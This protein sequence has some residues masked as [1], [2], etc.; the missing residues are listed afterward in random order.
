MHSGAKAATRSVPGHLSKSSAIKLPP[1]AA[2]QADNPFVR[3]TSS[4]VPRTSSLFKSLSCQNIKDSRSTSQSSQDSRASSREKNRKVPAVPRHHH[5]S[6][7]LSS[8]NTKL[9]SRSTPH[10]STSS[11]LKSNTSSATASMSSTLRDTPRKDDRITVNSD[12]LS[13]V[14]KEKK[15]NLKQE[16]EEAQTAAKRAQAEAESLKARLGDFAV[17]CGPSKNTQEEPTVSYTVSPSGP[18]CT[19]QGSSTSSYPRNRS[20]SPPESLCTTTL[21]TLG[22]ATS[23]Y[24]PDHATASLYSASNCSNRDNEMD[25]NDALALEDRSLCDTLASNS[26]TRAGSTPR[27]FAA[28][29]ATSVANLQG[30]IHEMEEANYTTTEELQATMEE[31]CDLQRTL[32]ESQDQNRTLAFERAILLESLCTQTAKLENC[33]FQIDQLKYLLMTHPDAMN[34]NSRESSFVELYASL[35][36]EKKVLLAQNNDLAQSSDSLAQECRVLTEKA[37][38]LLTS[39]NTLEGEHEALQAAHNTLISELNTFKS[40][41]ENLMSPSQPVMM[42]TTGSEVTI[43][44]ALA[45]E[46]RVLETR[47]EELTNSS[48]YWQDKFELAQAEYEREA[49]EW[50]LYE[51]DLLKTVRVADGIKA[52]SEEE[53]ARMA[54]ENHDLREQVSSVYL[55]ILTIHPILSNFRLTF[56]QFY[57]IQ[58]FMLFK[59]TRSC[60][61]ALF[62]IEVAAVGKFS[63]LKCKPDAPTFNLV[64]F[65]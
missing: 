51:R 59:V 52:E 5:S 63:R 49:T 9:S 48:K 47:I 30:R 15:Q 46:K 62:K 64:T 39:L 58:K 54:V 41:K 28:L 44:V 55:K 57:W 19:D 10:N 65:S 26:L 4:S 25:C 42:T 37:N 27:A 17:G 29:T 43:D 50:R 31:L 38:Q 33:R 14:E 40:E 8:L 34:A 23:N 1:K 61:R 3:P 16:K 20:R 53:M 36:E 11:V 32:D 2:H 22:G 7:T 12:L 56:C 6:S 60:L 21:M 45:S 24:H 35:E 18:D 13:R